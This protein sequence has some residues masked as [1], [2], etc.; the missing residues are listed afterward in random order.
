MT[1]KLGLR[2]KANAC[3]QTYGLGIK[4]V[5]RVDDAKHNP[6]EVWHTVGHPLDT[7][8]YGGGFL[9]HMEDNMVALG[10]VVG[11]DYK[12]PHLSPYR[13]FQ[14]YKLHPKVRAVLEG[15]QCLQLGL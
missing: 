15:G 11:L 8:T 4:E 13:E 14:R 7:Q 5:W 1:A 9:Y 10:L 12:N 2:D 6:G 3:P